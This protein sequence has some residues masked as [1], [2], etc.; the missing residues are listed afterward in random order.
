MNLKNIYFVQEETFAE[1]HI[2]SGTTH[3]KFYKRFLVNWT[4]KM[5]TYFF[6]EFNFFSCFF[7]FV[8]L[9]LKRFN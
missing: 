7:C 8:S 3:Y 6:S 5:V 4:L 9:R 1:F 2:F